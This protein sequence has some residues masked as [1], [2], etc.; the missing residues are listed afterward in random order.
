MFIALSVGLVGLCMSGISPLIYASSAKYTN[1]YPL[2]MGVLFTVG[3]L[4]GTLMPLTTGIIAEHLGFTAG[5]SAI[6]VTF[7]MLLV[8]AAINL[9]MSDK[10]SE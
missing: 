9:R 1:K 5:M 2:A 6:L 7:V 10:I 4:G 8:F 3:C